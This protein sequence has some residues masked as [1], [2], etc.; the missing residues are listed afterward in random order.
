MK[1]AMSGRGG[2]SAF[3]MQRIRWLPIDSGR[4]ASSAQSRPFSSVASGVAKT[5]FELRLAWKR[6]MGFSQDLTL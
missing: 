1:I 5:Y 6:G 3:S 2:T 4:M